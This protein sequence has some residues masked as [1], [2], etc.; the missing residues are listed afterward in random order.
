MDSLLP[1]DEPATSVL[2]PNFGHQ[3]T[4]DVTVSS[5]LSKVRLIVALKAGARPSESY[6][7]P[8]GVGVPL[9][10]DWYLVPE[11][12]GVPRGRDWYLVPEGVGVPRGRD[13]SVGR[14]LSRSTKYHISEVP[15]TILTQTLDDCIRGS[16]MLTRTPDAPVCRHQYR[17]SNESFKSRFQ[18]IPTEIC[19]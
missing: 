19:P 2:S 8:E 12:V 16:R 13:W 4:H 1:L 6:L 7:V 14:R 17:L 5:G 11:G 9:G 3:S 10:R 18:Q 15:S